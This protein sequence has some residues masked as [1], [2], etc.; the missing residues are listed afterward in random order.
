MTKDK[1]NIEYLINVVI[2]EN[3]KQLVFERQK[4]KSNFRKEKCLE[5]L[6]EWN[7]DTSEIK[8]S[9]DKALIKEYK[10]IVE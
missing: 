6:K 4:E 7:I 2:T 9:I 8:D 10:E 1:S 3:N 5:Q